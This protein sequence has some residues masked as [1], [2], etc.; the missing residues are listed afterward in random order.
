MAKSQNN[1]GTES[2]KYIWLIFV[3]LLIFGIIAVIICSISIGST[4][5][6]GNILIINLLGGSLVI[7]GAA[8]SSGGTLGLLFSVPKVRQTIVPAQPVATGQPIVPA[9]PMAPAQTAVTEGDKNDDSKDGRIAR[10]MFNNNLSEISDWLTKIIVGVGLTQLTNI[11]PFI[12]K[13]GTKLSPIFGGQLSG[14]VLAI[15]IVIYF[16]CAGFLC[17]YLWGNLYFIRLI[18]NQKIYLES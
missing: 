4:G 3:A 8:F 13:I 7:A 15:S 11:P 9:P 10:I 14:R 17:V 5:K 6:P 1:G 12:G 18:H 2:T 16:T